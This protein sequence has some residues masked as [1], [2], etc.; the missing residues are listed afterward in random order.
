L[1][2]FLPPSNR[3]DIMFIIRREIFNLKITKASIL[4][5]KKKFIDTFISTDDGYYKLLK[6]QESC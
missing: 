2:R 6:K 5:Y 1:L 4:S 3:S